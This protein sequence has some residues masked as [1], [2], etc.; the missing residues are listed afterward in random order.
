MPCFKIIIHVELYASVPPNPGGDLRITAQIT[1]ALSGG[2][3]HS[4]SRSSE[5]FSSEGEY[6]K[7]N[8]CLGI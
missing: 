4:S 2:F 5:L 1:L 3:G 8:V 7:L 6:Q